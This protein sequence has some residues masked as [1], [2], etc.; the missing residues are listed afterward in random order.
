LKLESYLE[1]IGKRGIYSPTAWVPR[2][3]SW[4]GYRCKTRNRRNGT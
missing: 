2:Q 1:V 3:Y 4:V